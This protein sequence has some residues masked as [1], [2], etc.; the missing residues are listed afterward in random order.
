MFKKI[1][2]SSV[3]SCLLASLAYSNDCTII[4]FDTS[5]SMDQYIRSEQDTRMNVAKKA[6]IEVLKDVPSTTKIGIVTFEGTVYPLGYLDAQKVKNSVLSLFSFG[7]TPLY[8]AIKISA[9]RLLLE[10]EVNGNV[11]LYKLLIVTDGEASDSYLNNSSSYPD[12]SYQPGILEDVI[13]RNIIL[14]VIALDMENDHLLMSSNNGLDM[15]GNDYESLKNSLSSSFAEVQINDSTED[16]FDILD[17]IPDEC[18]RNVITGLTSFRNQPIGQK[19]F[20][21]NY[22]D[23]AFE[24][25]KEFSQYGRRLGF[26]IL[27]VVVGFSVTIVVLNFLLHR[28]F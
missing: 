26:I 12:G 10:R 8:E 27:F 22:T 5:G 15:K 2:L 19:Y 20:T 18:S 17:G 9:D 16:T 23:V 1:L 11:G 4:V 25:Q 3:F 28:S 13:S 21:D 7:G 24:Y 14:D 6:L